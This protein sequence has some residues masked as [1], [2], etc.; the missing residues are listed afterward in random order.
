MKHIILFTSDVHGNLIQYD[1]LVDY[2]QNISADSVIIGGDIAPKNLRF[3]EIVKG[4]RKFLEEKLPELLSP[5]K[6]AGIKTY[7]IMGNDDA[8]A[9]MDVLERERESYQLIHNKRIKISEGFDIVG[10]SF[11]PITPFGLKDWEK[12]DL[13]RIPENLAAEYAHRKITNYNLDGFKSADGR[14]T[15]F[16][17]DSETEQ[18]DSIQDDLEQDLFQQNPEKTVYVMHSPPN[19]TNLDKVAMGRSVGSFAVREFIEK[20]LPYLTLHGHIHETVDVSGNFKA[21]IGNTLCISSGNDHAGEKIAAVVFDLY[22]L[23]NAKRI[24]I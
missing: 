6:K 24:F 23:R 12:Y 18:T 16:A 5:L 3:E 20:K 1:K 4:Q 9:N 2:A 22:N 14:L 17:F 11:V 7:L 19:K 15:R 13:S 10:Y 21:D 8:A